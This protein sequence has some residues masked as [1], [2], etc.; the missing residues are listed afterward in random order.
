MQASK[1]HLHN[2]TLVNPILDNASQNEQER[3]DLKN[4][5]IM[6]QDSAV[7]QIL[8]ECC[9]PKQDEVSDKLSNIRV[10]KQDEVSDKLSN[11][12]GV[13]YLNKM[14]LVIN[15]LMSEFMKFVSPVKHD[16]QNIG[17]FC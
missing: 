17:R 5:L 9:L 2:H 12:R 15:Y 1:V 6:A 16:Q 3:R 4:A 11:I 14:R 8:L 10:H 7:I 13:V